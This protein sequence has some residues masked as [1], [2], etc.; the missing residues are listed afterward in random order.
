[1]LLKGVVDGVYAVFL[2]LEPLHGQL[3]QFYVSSEV[4]RNATDGLETELRNFIVVA[5]A[6]TA[7][8]LEY[9]FEVLVSSLYGF[10][11]TTLHSVVHLNLK[12]HT[13]VPTVLED[14]LVPVDHR[15][16]PA[17]DALD[18]AVN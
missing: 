9:L 14:F 4:S 15:L 1:M 3:C 10:L 5:V 13:E 2:A 11:V 8:G 6:S 17:L 7:Y 16:K 18:H 12:H